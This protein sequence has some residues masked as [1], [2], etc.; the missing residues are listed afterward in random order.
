MKC[1]QQNQIAHAA[2]PPTLAK[3]ARMGHPSMGMVHAKIVKGG[4]ARP[5]LTLYHECR[6]VAFIW[7]QTKLETAQISY[8]NAKLED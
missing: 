3:N 8:G 6:L 2:S 7:F 5:S 1:S 4:P